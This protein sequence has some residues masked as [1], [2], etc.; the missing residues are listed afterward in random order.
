MLLSPIE[1]DTTMRMI[2]QVPMWAQRVIYIQG[3]CLKDADLARARMN[4]AEA[5]FV[6]AARNYCDKTAAVS[7]AFY[8]MI[9][10]PYAFFNIPL[11]IYYSLPQKLISE[12]CLVVFTHHYSLHY[13]YSSIEFHHTVQFHIMAFNCSLLFC[14][15]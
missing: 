6:L 10:L 14:R 2:L 5:C 9:L 12:S 8:L 4:D 11:S 1:L 15:Y 3:S 13:M 7:S